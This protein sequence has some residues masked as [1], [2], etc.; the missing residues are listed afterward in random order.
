MKLTIFQEVSSVD[1]SKA[2]SIGLVTNKRSI[3][4]NV[5]VDDGSIIVLGGLL[6]DEYSGSANQV[7]GL[8][9]LPV[10]GWLFK[11]ESR[12]RSK[13]NLMVFLRPVVVRDAASSE[14][15][16]NSRYQ[17]MMGMQQNAQPGFNPVLGS[18]NSP[19]LPPAP[20]PKPKEEPKASGDS[21]S[22]TPA[23]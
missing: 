10:L 14:A 11:S 4:S 22:E 7:P 17:Q 20:I 18:G 21:K 8:G 5:L 9:D 1:Y 2:A 13:K 19:V 23:Q 16:S 12:S 6:S 3:E 15:L